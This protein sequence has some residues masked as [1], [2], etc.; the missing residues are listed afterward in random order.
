MSL[1]KKTPLLQFNNS[2]PFWP[3]PP[4]YLGCRGSIGIL[5]V[6]LIQAEVFFP[7]FKKRFFIREQV[8]LLCSGNRFLLHKKKKILVSADIGLKQGK[9]KI[10]NSW[11]NEKMKWAIS[12]ILSLYMYLLCIIF[13]LYPTILASGLRAAYS[14]QDTI[15]VKI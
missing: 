4:N 13:C 2:R 14:I 8:K 5:L 15:T 6:L 9:T 1:F 12:T 11:A 3:P 10:V 7:L